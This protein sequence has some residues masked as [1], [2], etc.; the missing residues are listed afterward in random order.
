MG[1]V[2]VGMHMVSAPINVR[3]L[4][5]WAGQR[6]LMR[7]GTFDEGWALHVLLSGMFGKGA[8]QPFRMFWSDRRPTGTL[9]GYAADDGR[10]LRET[11][12]TV[13]P[14][15]F[16]SI[17]R[18]VEIRTKQMPLAFRP[19]QLLG[20]ELRARPVRRVS[21]DIQDAEHGKVVKKGSEIDAYWLDKLRSSRGD[22]A[23]SS[24][25]PSG[26]VVQRED[27]Y[28]EWLIARLASA[29]QVKACRLTSFRR[30]KALRGPTVVEGP[31]AILQGELEIGD[32]AQFAQALR[33]GVGRH[34]AYGYG[35]LLL[36]PANRRQRD[37][38]K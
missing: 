1:A 13:A 31:D 9:Y 38:G 20:F 4:M 34:K 37:A 23:T 10:A 30:A 33:H 24:S 18:P 25:L 36:R 27:C 19:G 7:R 6:G 17:I 35:M 28:R 5:K 16:C 21:E 26:D 8:L 11:A 2:E 12:T 22:A 15:E 3:A 14:P 29:A 32:P